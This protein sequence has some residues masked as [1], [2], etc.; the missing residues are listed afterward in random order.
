MTQFND[1]IAAIEEAEYLAKLH[2]QTYCVVHAD[3]NV[4][5]VIPKHEALETH[6]PILES[7]SHIGLFN[8]DD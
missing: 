2:Q 6:K 8:I 4:M 7:V 5:V 1:S 3:K